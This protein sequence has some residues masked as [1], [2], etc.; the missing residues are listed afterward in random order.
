M[1][2][3]KKRIEQKRRNIS[4]KK[5]KSKKRNQEK[6]QQRINVEYKT[7]NKKVKKK[8]VLRYICKIRF[9]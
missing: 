3:D 9:L 7:D 5:R 4:L 1:R 8:N 6:E 2:Y